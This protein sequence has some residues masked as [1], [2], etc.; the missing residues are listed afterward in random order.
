MSYILEALRKSEYARQQGKV[1]DLTTVAL[2]PAGTV[3]E[4]SG[5]RWAWLAAVAAVTLAL[6]ALG[7]LRPWQQAASEAAP[8]AAEP[9]ESALT[10]GRPRLA[11]P[12]LQSPLVSPSPTPLVPHAAPVPE[13]VQATDRLARPLREVGQPA[14]RPE[15]KTPVAAPPP[16]PRTT[17]ATD[18]APRPQAARFA[19]TDTPQPPPSSPPDRIHALQELPAPV[20]SALPALH[21][22]GYSYAD[23]TERPM[24]VIND[25]LVQ[26]GDEAAPGVTV[27]RIASDGVVL[28]YEGFR[29]RP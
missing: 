17:A 16:A 8:P 22:S 14:P 7:A 4:V 24:A 20:R 2:P 15:A 23:D 12:P 28:A 25:R 6:G 19:A 9:G 13:T 26:E 10:E 29:F 21:V 27:I 3:T 5:R 11:S 18:D 1:P